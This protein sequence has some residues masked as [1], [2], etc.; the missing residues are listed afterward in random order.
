M[1]KEGKKVL[2]NACTLVKIQQGFLARIKNEVEGMNGIP[3]P[4][5]SIRRPLLATQW[6]VFKP[7]SPGYSQYGETTY[8]LET[9]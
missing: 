7:C 8:L 4:R 2:K 9:G 6:S 1:K 5:N 3:G